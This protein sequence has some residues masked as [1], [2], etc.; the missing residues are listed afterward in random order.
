MLLESLP[1]FEELSVSL[2][3]ISDAE[4][5][6][7][8]LIFVVLAARKAYLTLNFLLPSLLDLSLGPH[9]GGFN[10]GLEAVQH[11]FPGVLDLLRHPFVDL[12]AAF[13]TFLADFGEWCAFRIINKILPGSVSDIVSVVSE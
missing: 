9:G 7:L 10:F 3:V 11:D 1:L 2:L 6:V 4:L 5:D 12:V 13:L 8:H